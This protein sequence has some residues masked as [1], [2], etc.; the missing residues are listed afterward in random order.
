[1]KRRIAI[2][3]RVALMLAIAL[4]TGAATPRRASASPPPQGFSAPQFS[5]I[6]A[7]RALK[8]AAGIYEW[9]FVAERGP[10]PFDRIGLHRIASGPAAPAHPEIVML[11]LPGTNMNGEVAVDDPRYSMPLYLAAHGVDVWA[12]DYRTHF[13]PPDTPAEKLAV[14]AGWTDRVFE[15]DITAAAAFVRA[16]TYS[17]KLFIA[18]F[19]RGASFAYL[20]A[21]THPHRVAGLV[22]LD[23]FVPRRLATAMPAGRVADDIG[24]RHLT[25][26]KRQTLMEAVIRDPGGPAPLPKYKTA[27]ENLEHVVYDADGVFGGHGGLAN[28]Q[29]GF[30]DPSVLARVLLGYDRWWPAVQNYEDYDNPF[31]AGALARLKAS[32][33]PVIA[34]AST[35]ISNQWPAMVSRSAAATGSA[36]LTIKRLQGWG[37]LDVICGTHAESEVFASVLAWLRRHGM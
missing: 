4:A 18:G 25:Y 3:L 34:F 21:A 12:M 20:F 14:M 9:H 7:P 16:K 15:G 23:G 24:G 30:S 2:A 33:I 1:M 28:P 22:I 27:A 8:G 37:H 17:E 36:D 10:S 32:K 35:N 6:G 13:V 26:D 5:L 19:S 29:G 11:Y 31:D